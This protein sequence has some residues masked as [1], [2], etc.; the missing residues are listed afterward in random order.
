MRISLS[1]KIIFF[2]SA[3]V[4]TIIV[5]TSVYFYNETEKI[6]KNQILYNLINIAEISEGQ[7]FLLFEKF[8]TRTSDWSSDGFIRSEFEEIIKSNDS[9]RAERLAEYVETEKKIMDPAIMITDIFNLDGVAVVS[10][11]KERI[12]HSEPLEEM[13][14]EYNFSQAKNASFGKAFASGLIYE[15][16]PGHS[17]PLWHISVPIVS[18]KTDEVIGVM[19]NHISGK[20]FYKVLSGKFQVKMG[21]KTGELFFTNQKTS[22]IYLVNKKELMITPS[23][24]AEDAV[25]KQKVDTEPIKKCF[26]ENQEFSGIYKNYLGKEVI[27]A[28]M[29]LTDQGLA[30][31]AEIGKDELFFPLKEKRNQ[32][33]LII[34]LIW[35]LSS[36]AVYWVIKFFLGNLIIIQKTAVEVAK[37]NYEVKA[38][39]K[40]K[41]EIGDLAVIFNDMIDKI[42]ISQKQLKEADIR[43]TAINLSLEQKVKERTAELEK[44]KAGL[45]Q[46]VVEKT[47]ELYQK[48]NELEKFKSLTVGR[49]L[50]MIELKKEIEA[51]KKNV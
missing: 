46:S 13:D 48:L 17:E 40:S 26:E 37:N 43:L 50:K 14:E 45:E 11:F 1:Y 18:L 49:E 33:I 30:L 20:E 24:F 21:A 2:F 10:T 27:G 42:K 32:A 23:R 12:G 34:G 38:T 9:Q 29:C 19:V 44:L 22:E 28:S 36:L 3:V 25:L 35:L 5:I 6:F 16:E 8:K 47:K 4:L 15:A 7:I 51:L 39:V 31:I 41:D